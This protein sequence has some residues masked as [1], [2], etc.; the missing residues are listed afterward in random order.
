MQCLSGG[1]SENIEAYF[2]ETRASSVG[3]VPAVGTPCANFTSPNC[4]PGFPYALLAPL[5]PA[6][7]LR[8]TG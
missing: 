4:Q 6:R 2:P 7:G 8:L 1:I 5:Y 3:E